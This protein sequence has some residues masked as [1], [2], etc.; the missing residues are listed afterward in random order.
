MSVKYSPVGELEGD[1]H[2]GVLVEQL[3]EDGNQPEVGAYQGDK[4]MDAVNKE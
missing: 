2:N 3:V 4:H 1:V